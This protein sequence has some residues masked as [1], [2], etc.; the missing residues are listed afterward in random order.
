MIIQIKFK[1][2]D[3]WNRPVFKDV[4][5]N[6]YYGSVNTLFDYTDSTEK[7]VDYFNMHMSELEWFG[8]KFDCEPYGGLSKNITL[9][10]ID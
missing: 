8:T 1:G 9:T 2:I 3:S 7:I 4:N 10:I 5:S 6:N